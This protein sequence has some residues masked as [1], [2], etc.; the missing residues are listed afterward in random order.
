MER[1]EIEAI[2]QWM[3]A[4]REAWKVTNGA[5]NQLAQKQNDYQTGNWLI[6]TTNPHIQT[7]DAA[8]QR[9]RDKLTVLDAA[10]KMAR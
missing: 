4:L 6:Q 10:E 3:Q 7:M 2:L 9:L 8:E 1:D 5:V